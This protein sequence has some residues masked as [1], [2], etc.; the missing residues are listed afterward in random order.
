M[1]TQAEWNVDTHIFWATGP[2]SAPTRSRISWAALLVKVMARIS[3]GEMP[4][5]RMRW[6]MRWVRTRVLPE[7]APAMT[8]RG[9]S[10]CTTASRCTGLRP[11]RRS[12]SAPGGITC[13]LPA[14]S[15]RFGRATPWKTRRIE[16]AS[17]DETPDPHDE[18]PAGP[19]TGEVRALATKSLKRSASLVLFLLIF[20]HLVI[21]QLGGARRAIH[22]L[23][24]VNPALLVLA[25]GLQI[26]AFAAY[27]QLTKVTLPQDDTVGWFTL[28][29]IQL[30]TKAVTN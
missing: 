16:P 10:S 24:D 2:T 4:R 14:P 21:P 25:L 19:T 20:N 17:S 7:P 22:L 3:N 8:R 30:S 27:T 5:S 15:D 1:R 23:S 9:P 13:T 11:S 6:A 26:G 28:F 29:R 12:G 18:R